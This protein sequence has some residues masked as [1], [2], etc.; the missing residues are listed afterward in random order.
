MN[1]GRIASTGRYGMARGIELSNHQRWGPSGIRAQ[2]V[3]IRTS[4]LE[5]DFIM[6]KDEKSLH[7]LNAVS[8]GWTCCLSFAKYLVA[9]I[10]A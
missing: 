10:T 1:Q 9:G 3:N 7:V 6:E 5:M 4:K 2:L 8:P